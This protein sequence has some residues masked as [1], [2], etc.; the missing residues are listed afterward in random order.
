MNRRGAL[1]F[2]AFHQGDRIYCCRRFGNGIS[3]GRLRTLGTVCTVYCSPKRESP[4]IGKTIPE[5]LCFMSAIIHKDSFAKLFVNDTPLL[6]LR[7]PVEFNRGAFPCAINAPLLSDDEREAIGKTYKA[8]GQKAAIALGQQLVSGVTRAERLAN[9]CDLIGR[10]PGAV[11]Y[12][13]RGGLRSQTVQ[14]WLHESSV[15]T[16]RVEGG[17]KALRQFLINSIEQFSSQC[18]LIIVAGKTGTGKTHLINALPNSM[19]LEGI[20][21]HRGSAFG[22]R[23]EPQANQINFEDQL[24]IALLKL[25]YN[26]YKKLFLEDE[27]RSIGSVSIP[28]CLHKKMSDS[29]IA[30]IEESMDNRVDTILN[31]YIISNYLDYKNSDPESAEKLFEDFL[32]SALQR[33]SRRLGPENYAVAKQ[34]MESAIKQQRSNNDLLYHRLWI[35]RLLSNYYDPMYEYQLNKKNHRIV[36]RGNK[37]EFQN[38]SSH[39]SSV[40]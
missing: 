8:K 34:E 38:W 3:P 14:T 16:A 7:S 25:P 9:W 30:V 15:E 5:F 29:A 6:D 37:T 13:F 23:K 2:D 20:A 21:N 32:L 18:E 33:I 40:A 17:Y 31:D 4:I 39:L 22:K 12:C 11:V 28:L 1:H 26:G 35:E 36:F 10:N 27:S 24:A 19:D